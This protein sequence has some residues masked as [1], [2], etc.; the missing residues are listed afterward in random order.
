VSNQSSV[1]APSGALLDRARRF[2]AEPEFYLNRNYRIP[3]RVRIV[4]ELV[5]ELSDARVLDLGCGDGSIATQFLP[6]NNRLTLVDYSAGMLQRAR[7][8]IPAQYQSQV[9]YVHG[10]IFAFEPSAPYDL[11][12][13]VGVLAHVESIDRAI[14]RAARCVK[15]GGRIVVQMS[16]DDQALLRFLR[17]L[18]VA[19]TR[20]SRWRPP[21]RGMTLSQVMAV[22]RKHGLEVTDQR[23]HLLLLIPGM[24][25]L[26]GKW[27][28]PYDEFTRRHQMLARHSTDVIL[29]CRKDLAPTTRPRRHL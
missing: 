29:I 15:P 22:L 3:L 17:M 24:M 4:R 21:S 9:E 7:S 8:S 11:V 26:L 19:R 16:D 14:E 6:S 18:Y 10:D 25:R 27:L 5:G 23:R 1:H 2:F 12:L 20:I 28:I 13:C